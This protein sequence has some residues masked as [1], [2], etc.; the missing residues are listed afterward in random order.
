MTKEGLEFTGESLI[1]YICNKIRKT[2]TEETLVK[3]FEEIAIRSKE[4]SKTLESDRR[5][6]SNFW[7]TDI[8][9]PMHAY[10]DIQKNKVNNPPELETKLG[11]GRI[12]E[13]R[14]KKILLTDP[15]FISSQGNVNGEHW[16][17]ADVTGRIDF[18][19][20]DTLIEF[21][22]SEEDV[23]DEEMVLNKHPQ[24]LEQLILYILFT[25]RVREEHRLLY[26]TG[27]YPNNE[28]RCF[29]VKI[30]NVKTIARYF[31]ER[32]DKLKKSL[33][34][35]NP[36]GLG[37]CRYFGS[38]CKFELSQICSCS[39]EQNIDIEKIRKNVSLKYIE[40]DLVKRITD[41]TNSGAVALMRFWD[42][43]TPRRFF[44]SE[45][46]LLELIEDFENEKRENFQLRMQIEQD[47]LEKGLIDKNSLHSEYPEIFQGFFSINSLKKTSSERDETK[48]YPI[49]IRVE[50]K[51]NKGREY[52]LSRYYKAQLGLICSL[53]KSDVGYVFVFFKNPEAGII[54]KL[55]FNDLREVREFSSELMKDVQK[56]LDKKLLPRNLPECPEFIKRQK[57]YREC[58]C[59]SQNN[60]NDESA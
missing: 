17:L 50:E 12:M 18:R 7:V 5:R 57:C 39:K 53:I 54:K 10:L 13:N 31:V 59:N 21:K 55:N 36:S 33:E 60:L 51:N 25:G 41:Y 24:D 23:P 15:E 46:Y 49:L 38:L 43:F 26:L 45:T 56:S 28:I 48:K 30:K 9:N 4:R 44:L 32:R 22:T 6:K 58:L 11:Y 27:K 3:K 52:E 19:L 47:L 1:K 20:R 35:L 8:I 29:K 16:G 42:I 34:N 37:K 40:D 2:T 14:I